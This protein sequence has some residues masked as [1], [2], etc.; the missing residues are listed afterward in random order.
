MPTARRRTRLHVHLQSNPEAPP[1]FHLTRERYAAAATRH[2]DVA[3][4][5]VATIGTDRESLERELR[6]A[7]VLVGFWFRRDNLAARA[8]R[9]KWIHIIGAGIDHLLPLDWLPPGVTLVNNRGVHATKA[10]EFAA[11]AILMLNARVPTMVAQQ[12]QHRW[13]EIF[14]TPVAGKTV[15]I[16][17]VGALG[18]AAATRARQLGLRVLGVRRTGRPRRHVHEMFTPRDLQRVLPRADFVIVATPLTRETRGLI[19]RRELDRL[20]PHAGLIN[21]C[22]APVVDYVA[23]A[24]KLRRGELSGAILDVFDPE[25][26]PQDSELWDTP[27]LI[28]TPH[29][30]SDDA[31]EYMPRTLDLLCENV[32]RYVAGRP[33]RNRV[34]AAREY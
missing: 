32:R 21:M 25:P 2:P 24:D 28:V 6:T 1:P 11:M 27:H 33:L 20:K 7:D 26:L 12:R 13:H 10:G 14:S 34:D 30:S 23:L 5:I 17:G 9:L 4:S 31:E 19:G 3:R 15:L 18:G 22:R 8:P 16:V 29:V